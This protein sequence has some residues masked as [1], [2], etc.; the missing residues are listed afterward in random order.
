MSNQTLAGIFIAASLAFTGCG[1]KAAGGSNSGGVGR[2]PLVCDN[3]V[4][5]VEGSNGIVGGSAVSKDSWLGQT[6][7]L[8]VMEMRITDKNGKSVKAYGKCTAS[9]L[10]RD[11]V[12]T[13]AHCVANENNE[14][15][16][17]VV[18]EIRAFFSTQ[19]ACNADKSVNL[20]SGIPVQQKE[21]HSA[22]TGLEDG[23]ELTS[24]IESGDLALLKLQWGAPGNWRTVK[25]SDQQ[26]NLSGGELLLAAGYG[27]TNPDINDFEPYE[28]VLRRTYLRGILPSTAAAETAAW[29]ARMEE[30]LNA[31][32]GSAKPEVVQKIQ[33]LLPKQS[34]YEMGADRDFLYVDQSQGVGVCRGD[35]GGAA[36]H[37]RNGKYYV[38]GVASWGQNGV[39]GSGLCS[40]MGAYTNTFRYKNW[41]IEKFNKLKNPGSQVKIFE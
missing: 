14:N 4:V 32:G 11:V 19:P 7:V 36:F 21:I 3:G 15:E 20:S 40:S 22:Y 27:R 12:L 6:V 34:Y 35:S 13:A 24:E 29:K 18:T 39:N 33:K 23:L 30:Y 26:V 37:Q 8:L 41:L 38:V 1:P 2:E 16:T 9:L 5:G 25:L 28:M 10:D 31:M 17:V